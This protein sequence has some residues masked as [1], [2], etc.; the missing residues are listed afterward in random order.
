[1]ISLQ[2]GKPL[3]IYLPNV[4]RYMDR[5]FIDLFFETGQ[6]RLSSFKKF[7]EYPDEIRGDKNEGSG[8]VIG[9]SDNSNFQFMVMSGAGDNAYM[10]CGSII[11]S[12]HIKNTF[13]TESCFR[14]VN[15]LEFSV[16]VSNAIL[17]F[18][19]S[20]QGFCNYRDNRFIN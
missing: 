12:E 8:S 14:I 9:K 15:P 5:K 20:F 3:D 13:N 17:G 4:Y 11:E 16:A 7:R 2:H 19:H 18:K 10:L 1:M 6:L